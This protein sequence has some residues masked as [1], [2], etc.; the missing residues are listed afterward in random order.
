MKSTTRQK[1]HSRRNGS[2]CGFDCSSAPILDLIAYRT[3]GNCFYVMISGVRF[4]FYSC[5]KY[6]GQKCNLGIKGLVWFICPG[7]SLSLKKFRAGIHAGAWRHRLQQR[8]WRSAAYL[9]G[10]SSWLLSLLFF[11]MPL[12]PT[13]PHVTASAVD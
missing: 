3:M 11:L 5:D 1:I 7:H 8:L 4:V 13:S 9:A 6:I 10:W 2:S 12:S